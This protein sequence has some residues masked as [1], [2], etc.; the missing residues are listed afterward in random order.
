M[1]FKM[2][3]FS[4]FKKHPLYGKL[5]AE[6]KKLYDSLSKKVQ[7]D[8]TKENK[9]LSQLRQALIPQKELE[10]QQDKRAKETG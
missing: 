7:D 4:G 2:G 8:Y 3:S 1:A 6:E 9:T 10:R 5:S